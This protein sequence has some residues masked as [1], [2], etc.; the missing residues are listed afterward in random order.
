MQLQ[1]ANLEYDISFPISRFRSGTPLFVGWVVDGGS[2]R[3]VNP[4][5][6]KTNIYPPVSGMCTNDY[7]GIVTL[8]IIFIIHPGGEE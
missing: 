2:C 6:A 8:I 3:S 4:R 7:Q 1:L 5:R